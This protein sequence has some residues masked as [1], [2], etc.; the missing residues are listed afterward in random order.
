[1]NPSP[2]VVSRWLADKGRW[3]VPRTVVVA[4][5]AV[6]I[7]GTTT[8]VN[9]GLLAVAA[10]FLMA[11]TAADIDAAELYS[12]FPVDIFIMLVSL[13]FL[14]GIARLNGAVDWILILA[15]QRALWEPCTS[16]KLF[17]PRTLS[18]HCKT[19]REHDQDPPG[20]GVADRPSQRRIR[21][22]DRACRDRE[23]T[24]LR[25]PR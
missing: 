8:N 17:A 14:L 16:M 23:V 2:H 9:L 7:I 3:H 19:M 11:A 4:L 6:V 22:R 18:S 5:V 13:M 21:R 10:A 15:V 20:I 24:G 1:M 12:T 25:H